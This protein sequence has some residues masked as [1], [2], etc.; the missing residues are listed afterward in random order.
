MPADPEGDAD[1]RSPGAGKQAVPVRSPHRGAQASCSP[2]AEAHA[3]LE[4]SLPPAAPVT[5]GSPVDQSRISLQVMEAF[6]VLA[7]GQRQE[8]YVRVS[9]GAFPLPDGLTKGYRLAA[10]GEDGQ[11][12]IHLDSLSGAS[13][14]SILYQVCIHSPSQG[15]LCVQRGFLA[16]ADGSGPAI[17]SAEKRT[18]INIP[19]ILRESTTPEE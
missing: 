16:Q 3:Q 19:F 12:R 5:G 14:A 4:S 1:L 8:V 15:R 18:V 11:T 6:P 2:Q 10:T 13:E 7:P 17:V 9:E